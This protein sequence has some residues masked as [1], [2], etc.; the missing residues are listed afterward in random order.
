MSEA[1]SCMVDYKLFVTFP[2]DLMLKKECNLKHSRTMSL[3]F[4]LYL[5]IIDPELSSLPTKMLK[6]LT[7]HMQYYMKIMHVYFF[8]YT[9]VYKWG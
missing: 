7:V 8:K 5:L 6:Y 9:K 1:T 4:S 3:V 2:D